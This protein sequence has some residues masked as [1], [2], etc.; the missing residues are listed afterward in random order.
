ME[1]L[2]DLVAP[3]VFG[4]FGMIDEGVTIVLYAVNNVV[5]VEFLLAHR[6][7]LVPLEQQ[8]LRP[9]VK[10]RISAV[11]DHIGVTPR[12]VLVASDHIEICASKVALILIG[13]LENILA[14]AA[15]SHNGITDGGDT[16]VK[17]EFLGAVN[18][19]EGVVAF[20][21][22]CL[23]IRGIQVVE[24]DIGGHAGIATPPTLGE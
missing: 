13:R 2:T 11:G 10:R 3:N 21:R 4:E 16:V 14:T 20:C 5:A 19:A 6:V 17:F 8:T 9:T 15:L 22:I 7:I 1:W 18:D 23:C 24:I 12:E